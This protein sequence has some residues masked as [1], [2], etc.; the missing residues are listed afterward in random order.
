M[1]ADE[2]REQ[3]LTEAIAFF[4]EDGFEGATR[5]LSERIGVTQPL[6]YKYFPTKRD[7][8]DAVYERV[9][10]RRLKPHWTALILDRGVPILERMTQFYI[11]Y[12][13]A[14]L[15]REWVR[16]FMFAGLQGED[17]NLRYLKQ[18]EL[19]IIEPL[20]CEITIAQRD[21]FGSEAK[22]P[23]IDDIWVHHGGMFYLGIREHVYGVGQPTDRRQTIIDAVRRF[24]DSF[25]R[26]FA[27]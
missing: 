27:V 19:T 22:V 2:R 26:T 4:T 12:A 3:I 8:I 20:R 17:L 1:P 14:V 25:D 11:E 9:Y 21:T 23:S 7:L 13:D 5:E 10:L 15:T 18:L 6:L 16:L 24:L